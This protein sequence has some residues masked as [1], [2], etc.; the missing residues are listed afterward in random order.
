M[1]GGRGPWALAL[2]VVLAFGPTA[3]LWAETSDA[4]AASTAPVMAPLLT[5]DDERLFKESMFGKAVLARQEA[6]AQGLIAENRRIEAA[7][8]TEEKDLTT[9]RAV[10][11]SAEFASLSEAFNTK[12]EGIRKAQDAKSRDLARAFDDEKLRFFEAVRPALAQLM[13]ERGAVAIIDKRAVFV[14]FENVDI[15]SAAI[16]LLDQSLGDGT[17]PVTPAP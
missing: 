17:E 10:M 3:P 2:G 15:T 9:R 11:T 16:E 6:E 4:A 5:L 1:A 13:K 12:V 8:E 14:G 7:L